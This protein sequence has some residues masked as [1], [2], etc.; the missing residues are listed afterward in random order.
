MD[1]DYKGFMQDFRTADLFGANA[2]ED[3]FRRAW[4]EW[5]ENADYFSS[6]T[7]TLNHLCWYHHD[8]GNDGYCRLY[9]KL[10]RKAAGWCYDHFTAK[11]DQRLIF[12]K[13]D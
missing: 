4:D 5:K 1:Y 6:M 3:T 2:I 8:T 10:Y 12:E 11:D 9:E 13:L 7:L